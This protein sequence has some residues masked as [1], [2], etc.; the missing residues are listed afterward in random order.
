MFRSTD[1][2]WQFRMRIGTRKAST[3]FVLEREYPMIGTDFAALVQRADY[4]EELVDTDPVI[5]SMCD[6]G[7]DG[8]RLQK[9][10]IGS[11]D[12][13][14]VKLARRDS[15]RLLSSLCR[16]SLL[17][18]ECPPGCRSSIIARKSST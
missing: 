17:I 4:A 15:Q 7:C 3:M 2:R 16:D 1:A 13:M 6:E 10:R 12:A 8:V 14:R 5:L 11:T 18:R 9:S